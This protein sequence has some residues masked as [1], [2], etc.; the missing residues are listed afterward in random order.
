MKVKKTAGR[1]EGSNNFLP[2]KE[3]Q[4][5]LL[6]KLT[7]KADQGDTL[8]IIGLLWVADLKKYPS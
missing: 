2:T 6:E 5:Q 3:K 8:A 7:E 4:N 1:P